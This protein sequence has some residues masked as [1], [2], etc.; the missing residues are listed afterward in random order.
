MHYSYFPYNLPDFSRPTPTQCEYL[1]PL[2]M[3]VLKWRIL[4]TAVRNWDTDQQK[5]ALLSVGSTFLHGLKANICFAVMPPQH[6]V[7]Q[8]K[9]FGVN[10]F[11]QLCLFPIWWSERF[12]HRQ[13]E[14]YN[15]YFSERASE[16]QTKAVC[17]YAHVVF[18]REKFIISAFAGN[19]M[20]KFLWLQHY[21]C[22][23]R[24]WTRSE[25]MPRVP[26]NA[27]LILL[28]KCAWNTTIACTS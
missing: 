13:W 19:A 7:R 9:L 28:T 27:C 23:P 12:V 24:R 3:L 2:G 4:L 21:S 15:F 22:T 1:A 11:K 8:R 14:D 18:N 20:W 10:G 17:N 25:C 26:E 5:P 6:I 16:H